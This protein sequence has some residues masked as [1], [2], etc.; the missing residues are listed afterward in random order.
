MD[1]Q[2]HFMVNNAPKQRWRVV[3]KHNVLNLSAAIQESTDHNTKF[4]R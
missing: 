4:T 1:L 3:S 2:L